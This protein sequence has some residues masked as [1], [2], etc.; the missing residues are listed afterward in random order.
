MKGVQ[1]SADTGP[2]LH[3]DAWPSSSSSPSSFAPGL[4]AFVK[5]HCL[6]PRFRPC[7]HGMRPEVS[8]S[9]S[10][11]MSL[12]PWCPGKD[13]WWVRA[14]PWGLAAAGM[15]E[16]LPEED[17]SALLGPS[18]LGQSSVAPRVSH[19]SLSPRFAA[20]LK[21]MFF[22]SAFPTEQS[23]LT[24]D[25][26]LVSKLQLCFLGVCRRSRWERH[27]VRSVCS[28]CRLEMPSTWR[29]LMRRTRSCCN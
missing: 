19:F 10:W 17:L 7:V 22:R 1:S 21:T 11:Q 29:R 12:C 5:G 23:S 15:A 25:A 3:R 16:A 24:W 26:A 9:G 18:K 20:R 4:A 2:A 14:V 27:S 13:V 6:L 8:Q 28:S